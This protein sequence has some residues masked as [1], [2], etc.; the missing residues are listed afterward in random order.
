MIRPAT[1][2]D[3]AAITALVFEVLREY[4][5]EPDPGATD[6]DLKDIEGSYAERGGCFDVL[7]D[8]EGRIV[9]SVGLYP[10]VDGRCELRKMYLHRRERGK[11]VGKLLLEHALT[12]AVDLGFTEVVLETASALI[13]ATRLYRDHG[14]VPYDAPHLSARCDQ[15]YI[16]RLP[17]EVTSV[18]PSPRRTLE[19]REVL[20]SDAASIRHLIGEAFGSG[21]E[22]EIAD[23]VAALMADPTARPLV[24]LVAVKEGEVVG[25]ILFSRVRVDGVG[26]EA[27]ATILAPLCGASVRATRMRESEVPW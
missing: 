2:A 27:R 19:I 24:S 16:K 3:E 7:L 12:R 8:G 26:R 4:G 6:A 20:N 5:L 17:R 13:E 11:G 10:L 18:E 25:H 14:F 9:G 22:T 21:E 23:L 1:N 15:A